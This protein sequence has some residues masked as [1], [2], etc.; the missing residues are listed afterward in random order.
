MK[1]DL[2][3]YEVILADKYY[4]RE[5]VESISLDE[6]L[7][8]IA[9]R[10]TVR[11]KNRPDLPELLPGQAIEIWGK[12]FQKTGSEPLLSGGV[13]WEVETEKRG[14]IH[15][16][17]TIF[18]KMVYL[19]KSEDEYLFPAG[20]T[21]TQRL[22]RYMSDWQITPGE[23]A[24]TKLP[25]AR[26]VFR[27]QPIYSMIKTDLI[28]TATKGGDMFRPRMTAGILDL[29][30]LGGNE[31]IWML[32]ADQNLESI[33]EKNT[34]ESVVTQV[35]VLGTDSGDGK[36]APVLAVVKGETV[37]YGTIQK[38]LNDSKIETAKEAET[39][40]KKILTESRKSVTVECL[41]I[42]S[43]RAGDKVKLNSIGLLVTSVRHTLGNPG[44]MTLTL[45]TEEQV[46]REYYGQ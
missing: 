20:Q 5:L 43:I 17:L 14:Q 25:L 34:L 31:T 32:E 44:H 15:T 40:A 3:Y 37:Q 10:A 7:D 19:G 35:K 30:K 33:V 26:S 8:E 9:Y 42:N 45:A 22:Q 4:L 28:E 13:I 11:I 2:N 18:D 27:A 38:V 6:S 46:R 36:L 39:A 21:A 1:E 12:P 29:I 16:A 23:L 41:D 24:D